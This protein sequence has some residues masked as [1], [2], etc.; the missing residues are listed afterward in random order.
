MLNV[1]EYFKKMQ[2]E[3]IILYF[4]GEI[5]DSLL[6]SILQLIDDKLEKKIEDSKVKKKVFSILLECLQNIYNYYQHQEED[7]HWNTAILMIKKTEGAYFVITGNYM[8]NE[9]VEKLRSKLIKVNN[10]TPEELKEYYKEILNANKAES[11]TG[12]A[13]LGLID[14]ARKSGEKIDYSFDVVNEKHCFYS[15]QVKVPLTTL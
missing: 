1:Y 10:M 14:I 11:D 9:R 2:D 5:T 12:G 8:R 4:K 13:G 7:Q 6:T 15:L 3:D